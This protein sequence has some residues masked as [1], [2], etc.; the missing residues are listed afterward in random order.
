DLILCGR[1]ASDTDSG[2]VLYW[3]ASALDVAAVSPVTAIEEVADGMLKGRRLAGEGYHHL[4][5]R[6]PALVGLSGEVHEPR[7][8]SLRGI[9]AGGRAH[10]PGWK[11]HDL[12]LQPREPKVELRGLRVPLRAGRAELVSGDS[13]GAQGIALADKLRERGLI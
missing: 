9:T 11:A 1:Q 8:P 3:L 13:G 12:G 10:I 6:L 4:R 7:R 2:Q 5:V